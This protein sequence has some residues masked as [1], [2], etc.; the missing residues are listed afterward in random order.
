MTRMPNLL[1]L[2]AFAVSLALHLTLARPLVMPAVEAPLPDEIPTLVIELQGMVS[3]EQAEEQV[4]QQQATEQPQQSQ[5]PQQSV[6]P[7]A[8]QDEAGDKPP[9]P[10]P[11]PDITAQSEPQ[12][13]PP[14][15]VPKDDPN[16]RQEAQTLKIERDREADRLR[17]YIKRLT[18]KIQANLVYPQEGRRAGLQG[19]ATVSFRLAADGQIKPGTLI[20]VASSGQP[21]LDASALATARACAPFEPPPREITVTLVVGYGRKK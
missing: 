16:E 14:Q 2:C 4:A 6:P 8:P 13:V 21:R 11:Q 10:Q 7:P 15:T 20:I 9:D 18:K 5:Q 3:D 19:N 17:E 12:P 1:L